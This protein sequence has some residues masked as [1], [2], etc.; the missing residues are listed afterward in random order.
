VVL[1]G[2][3]AALYF[4]GSNNTTNSPSN[5]P[6]TPNAAAQSA[7]PA[8]P[9]SQEEEQQH[10]T[11]PAKPKTVTLQLVPTATV[12]VCV[13]NGAGTKLIAGRVFAAGE[14]DPDREG[15]QAADHAW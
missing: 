8:P 10:K 9:R 7:N 12:Y 4:V 1:V 15:K 2:I 11:V 13:E 6:T 5:N 14:D 3:V